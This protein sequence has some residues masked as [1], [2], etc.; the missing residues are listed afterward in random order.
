MIISA[1]TASERDF[2]P[3]PKT[4]KNKLL[5]ADARYPDFHFFHELEQYGGFYIVQGSKSL[6]PITIEA[7]NGRGRLL[8]K[9]ERKKMKDIVEVPIVHKFLT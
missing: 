1:D 7:R 9:L 5:L 6:N 2:L 4:M 3:K 8:T